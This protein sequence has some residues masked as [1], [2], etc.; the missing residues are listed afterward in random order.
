MNPESSQVV[1][2]A[3]ADPLPD[4]SLSREN[5]P[6]YDVVKAAPAYSSATG[7]VSGFA[8]A[9]VVLVLTVAAS[10]D[11]SETQRLYLG[12]ATSLFALGFVGCLF[13][14]FAFASLG[15]EVTSPATLTYS[16]LVG[17]GVLISLVA[18]LGGF[19]ALARAFLPDSTVVFVAVAA[20]T[21]AVS[22]LFVWFPHWDIIQRFSEPLYEGPPV[23]A[24]E[25]RRLVVGL[26]LFG[27]VCS[28]AGVGL[29]YLR[30]LGTP[31]Q[32]EYLVV[33]FTGLVYVGVMVSL[34]L[35]VSTSSGRARPTKGETWA[36]AAFQSATILLTLA[37]LP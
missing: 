30:A 6:G 13:C 34:A 2:V 10:S 19:E 11:L 33:T 23:S 37:L 15:G 29:H 1:T 12:F 24:D 9:A 16:M 14:A 35:F 17:S 21:A 27:A 3:D 31:Q 8:L 32:W 4:P 28:A 26:W 7:L 22:P 20:L 5:V 18:V 36:L 25:A